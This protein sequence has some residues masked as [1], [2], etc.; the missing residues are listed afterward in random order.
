MHNSKV[1]HF[2]LLWFAT[3]VVGAPAFATRIYPW[4]WQLVVDR[5]TAVCMLRVDQV[6]EYAVWGTVVED[7]KGCAKGQRFTIKLEASTWGLPLLL[8]GDEAL[9]AGFR[10]RH[11][12]LFE[13]ANIRAPSLEEPLRWRQWDCDL[14]IPFEVGWQSNEDWN[15]EGVVWHTASWRTLA[16]AIAELRTFV[17]MEPADRELEVMRAFATD[18][19]FGLM[20]EHPD[21]D[22]WTAAARK[23]RSLRDYL[24][25]CISLTAN[26]YMERELRLAV[27]GVVESL[28]WGGVEL[29]KLMNE[30]F[31]SD[32]WLQSAKGKSV[33]GALLRLNYP[34]LVAINPDSSR[35]RIAGSAQSVL[36]GVDPAKMVPGDLSRID[37]ATQADAQQAVAWLAS[38]TKFEGQLSGSEAAY[39][40]T[41]VIVHRLSEYAQRRELL[42]ILSRH[43]ISMVRVVVAA[44]LVYDCKSEGTAVLW[45][46]LKDSCRT[47]AA[48]AALTLARWG[49]KECVEVCLEQLTAWPNSQRYSWLTEV[50]RQRLVL[51]MA[52]SVRQVHLAHPFEREFFLGEQ[53]VRERLATWWK[54]AKP[55]AIV[56]DPLVFLVR[57]PSQ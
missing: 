10:A 55:V 6:S 34:N 19:I 47:T 28:N 13:R 30:D 31:Q 5:A 9:V 45:T 16:A 27:E 41:S 1:F 52:N 46:A 44:H 24:T 56:G 49:H 37:Y 12:V 57:K 42:A 7:V 50:V 26:T 32:P 23:P 2:L 54:S 36:S 3:T 51:L 21:L 20:G 14:V 4:T 29:L 15:K 48:L 38:A 33:A 25:W 40:V 8:P 53:P 11:P 35:P 17:R 39:L 43:E 22:A 18:A